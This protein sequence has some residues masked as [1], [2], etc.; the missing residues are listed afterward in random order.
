MALLV[1]DIAPYVR[2]IV[3]CDAR[4]ARERVKAGNLVSEG[5]R[6][7]RARTTR[8]AMA[9]LWGGGRRARREWWFEGLGVGEVE[10]TGGE[11]WADLGDGGSEAEELRRSREGTAESGR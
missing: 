9:A 10:R 7:K 2:G 5:G 4:A 11:G 6:G 1:T 8:A 3:A